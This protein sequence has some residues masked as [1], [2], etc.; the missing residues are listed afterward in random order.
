VWEIHPHDPPFS[1]R[2]LAH[3]IRVLMIVPLQPLSFRFGLFTP[4]A[5]YLTPAD[6]L[7]FLATRE[8]RMGLAASALTR[9]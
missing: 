4:Q 3:D 9:S 1:D 5:R 8:S 7:P 6:S 2:L